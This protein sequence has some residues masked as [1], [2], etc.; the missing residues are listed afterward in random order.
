MAEK[1]TAPL[2]DIVVLG[3][4]PRAETLLRRDPQFVLHLAPL[5][6]GFAGAEHRPQ[7]MLAALPG[8]NVASLA[9][10]R[11]D[12]LLQDCA[13][14]AL[15]ESDEAAQEA[16]QLVEFD[17]LILMPATPDECFYARLGAVLNG[18]RVRAHRNERNRLLSQIDEALRKLNE[19]EAVTQAAA[20]LLGRHL[21]ASRCA[22]ADVEADEDTINLTGN[23]NDGVGSIVGRYRLAQYGTECLTLMRQGLPFVVEDVAGDPRTQAVLDTYRSA[24]IGSGIWVPL[25]HEGRLVAAMAVH[26]LAPRRWRADEVALLT[27]VAG[28]CR[29]S[30][31]RCRIGRTLHAR[32]LRYR[33]LVE[34]ASSIVWNTD[35][36]GMLAEGN[37]AWAE[38]T[39][40]SA[41][42]YR[43]DGWLNALHPDDRA[44]TARNWDEAARSGKPFRDAYRLRRHDG[45]Y[46][47]MLV[48]GAPVIT[49]GTVREWVGS[50]MDVTDIREAQEAARI[51]NARLQFTLDSARIA[52]WDYDPAN[53][54]LAS[55][56]RLIRLFGHEQPPEHWTLDHVFAQVHPAD[57]AAVRSSFEEA[58]RSGAPWRIECRIV[59]PDSAVH[60]IAV[61]GNL[62]RDE[63][64]VS[65]R[66]LGIVYDITAHKQSEA[67]LQEADR[68]KDEFLAM[69]AHELRNPLAPIGAAAEILALASDDRAK[70]AMASSVIGRQVRH[71]TG[72]IDDLLDVSRVK[73]GL[74]RL[75]MRR[76]DMAEVV[77]TALEQAR[78]AI[79]QHR[80]KLDLQLPFFEQVTVTGDE[81]RLVQVV[82]NLLNN[83]AKYTPDGGH[84]DV[85]LEQD[86][87]EVRLVVR[88]NGIGMSPQFLQRAFDVFAQADQSVA[89][90]Q[91]GL[92]LGLALARS[93][94]KAHDGSITAHSDGPGVGASFT[95]TLP[96][97]PD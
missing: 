77:S 66:M 6:S 81:K 4:S 53:R 40:Q 45:E 57:I 73:R 25:L 28:R 74:V 38:F 24:A 67:A 15:L 13:L 63:H 50:C 2:I 97:A 20:E 95:V 82:A 89:R 54:E 94:I 32:E 88:D 80:H 55:S 87:K 75:E 59:W 83:A 68:R 44:A 27:T 90:S 72:L 18:A 92:G 61:H 47:H 19:P 56:P 33:T 86:E 69:L 14:V 46:R 84:I 49:D 60:W 64:S 70:L 51:A 3:S 48:R 9:R 16:E 10:L 52:D 79:D 11:N 76:C 62:Y 96:R 78:P 22:Y 5:A 7:L 71:M 37:T 1:R 93:L 58:V 17:D 91:G 12:P 35:P 26:D 85:R 39:G 8:A 65:Q 43:G 41:G 23:Y 42:E 31:E 34:T 36:Q 29:E 21:G 30:I